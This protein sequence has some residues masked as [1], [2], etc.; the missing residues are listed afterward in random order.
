MHVQTVSGQN[1][2]SSSAVTYLIVTLIIILVP[3]VAELILVII[4]I[5]EA[6]LIEIIK[7]LVLQ[8]LASE[9]VHSAGNQLLLDVLAELVVEL[10]AL[11]DI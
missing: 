10:K 5:F 6:L 7:L 4:L 2:P 8:C 9:P 1:H 3:I 11:L